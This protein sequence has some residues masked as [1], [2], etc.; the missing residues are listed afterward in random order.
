MNGRVTPSEL[1]DLLRVV[2]ALSIVFIAL[3]C[4]SLASRLRKMLARG[5]SSA[6]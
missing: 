5:Q 1:L 6:P 3:V 4:I 2:V